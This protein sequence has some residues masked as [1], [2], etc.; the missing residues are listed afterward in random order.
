[1]DDYQMWGL[2]RLFELEKEDERPLHPRDLSRR[3]LE[4]WQ[5]K[6]NECS[7]LEE[8]ETA[9]RMTRSDSLLN[10]H[11][12]AKRSISLRRR[13]SLGPFERWTSSNDQ[14]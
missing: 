14:E 3:A 9:V 10:K 6:L 8:A 12:H 4:G 1:M 11:T 13:N 7:T 5:Q 2:A